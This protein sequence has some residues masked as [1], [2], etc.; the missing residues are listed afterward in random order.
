VGSCIPVPNRSDITNWVNNSIAWITAKSVVNTFLSIGYYH[1]KDDNLDFT[2]QFDDYDLDTDMDN[3]ARIDN[4]IG[5]VDLHGINLV[6]HDVDVQNN[7][8]LW[9]EV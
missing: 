8:G 6:V 5:Q 3:N 7:I 2:A 9:E 4:D 1:P